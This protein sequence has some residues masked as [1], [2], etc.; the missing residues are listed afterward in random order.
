MSFFAF[1]DI[2]ASG[3]FFIIFAF[4]IIFLSATFVFSIICIP[5]D[6]KFLGD[7]NFH[8]CFDIFCFH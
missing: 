2:F 3:F 4:Q 7:Y 8:V 5:L 1:V 6:N